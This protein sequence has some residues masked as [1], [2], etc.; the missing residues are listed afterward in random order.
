MV[1]EHRRV[2]AACR[3][4][5]G[6]GDACGRAGQSSRCAQSSRFRQAVHFS[7]PVVDNRHVECKSADTQN[8]DDQQREHHCDGAVLTGRRELL[9]TSVTAQGR[10]G[11]ERKCMV[12]A[13][14]VSGRGVGKH[15]G[16][17]QHD[18]FYLPAPGDFDLRQ[19]STV[20]AI[21]REHRRRASCGA[22]AHR[23]RGRHPLPGWRSL[24]RHYK[25]TLS[26]NTD[27]VMDQISQWHQRP[28]GSIYPIMYFH[29]LRLKMRDD[30]TVKT[31]HAWSSID[32]FMA[33]H[34]AH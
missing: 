11:G 22:P 20:S 30:Q 21:T 13:H 29:A 34:S 18:Q 19:E 4:G 3:I 8:E 6:V 32:E 9:A 16:G 12:R 14:E 2:G 26:T 7:L 1:L 33:T 24:Q 28:L 23:M 17:A 15:W 27:E 25:V 10:T 5:R 31:N